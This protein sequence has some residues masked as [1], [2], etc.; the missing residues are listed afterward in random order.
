[1]TYLKNTIHKNRTI[2]VR[3]AGARY[4]VPD[5]T[6]EFVYELICTTFLSFMLFPTWM[7]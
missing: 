5:W 3:R 4:R 2:V 1:M 6:R 7:A